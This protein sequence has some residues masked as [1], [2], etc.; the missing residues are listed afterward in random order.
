PRLD[1]IIARALAG[2]PTESLHPA[3]LVRDHRPDL[4]PALV[5][6]ARPG[7][8]SAIVGA[9]F[10][11]RLALRA[12]RALTRLPR[13]EVESALAFAGMSATPEEAKALVDREIALEG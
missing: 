12:A 8:A 3:D 2:G 11:K 13:D 4:L 5:D 7:S 9:L 10:D 6:M 1:P